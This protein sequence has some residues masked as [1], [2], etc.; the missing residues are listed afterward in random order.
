MLRPNQTDNLGFGQKRRMELNADCL[1]G[2]AT[3]R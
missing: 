2:R 3:F 1:D